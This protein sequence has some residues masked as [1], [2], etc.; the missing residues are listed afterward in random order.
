[1]RIGI[2]I[3]LL[4]SRRKF[5]AD[6]TAPAVLSRA[7]A[8]N[9]TTLTITYDEN[10]DAGSTPAAGDYSLISLFW[11]GSISSVNVSGATVVLTLSTAV[12]TDDVLGLTY[13]VPG[14]GKV[15]DSA[16]NNAVGFIAQA[17]TN[18][19]T[20]GNYDISTE[21]GV[22]GHFSLIDSALTF[23]NASLTAGADLSD[24]SWTKTSCTVTANVAGTQ[25]RLVVTGPAPNALAT[26]VNGAAGTTPVPLTTTFWASYETIQWVQLETRN[27]TAGNQVWFDIQNGAVGTTG[28]SLASA[29]ITPETRNGV[30][31]Y[32]CSVKTIAQGSTHIVRLSLSTTN[33]TIT[34]PA[35][36]TAMRFDDVTVTQVRV[37]AIANKKTGVTAT[38]ATVDLQ[39]G[40]DA[41]GLNGGPCLIGDGVRYLITTEA[42]VLLANAAA[43]S[44]FTVGSIASTATAQ[45]FFGYGDAVQATARTRAWG[46]DST[47]K[48]LTQ[49]RNDANANAFV[50]STGNSDTNVNVL[51][52]ASP[53][54][55][56]DLQK[57]G[58]AADPARGG[59]GALN[60]GTLTPGRAGIMCR[61]SSTVG[62]ILVGKWAAAT[63]FS[64][65]ASA[66]VRER[67]R[68]K[69]GQQ[70]GITV[71]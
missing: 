46:N 37:S 71:S 55:T 17:V 19:S 2:N 18:G 62:L 47:G 23:S 49:A 56:F 15:R 9:G 5:G 40:Y 30:A 58:G 50:D 1:M 28:G 24:A 25:D 16:G 13:T 60:P 64:T 63:L 51:E 4:A 65:D 44:L 42:A 43:Y 12:T 70:W 33:T 14:S 61:P 68:R 20:T 31:G 3:G 26:V 8:A 35:N 67:V 11:A 57:N 38:Q 7:L 59:T 10:L 32:R 27:A 34:N 66:T 41:T 69:L 22:V 53:G 52:W 6:T 48:W 45:A 54:T 36:S 29:S 39:P 21:I